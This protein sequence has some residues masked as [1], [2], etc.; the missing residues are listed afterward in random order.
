MNIQLSLDTCNNL[1]AAALSVEKDGRFELIERDTQNL[2]RGHAE[3]LTDQI[4][5]ILTR[6]NLTFDDVARI[7]VT[8]GP[9]SFTGQ[10]VGLATA[11]TLAAS[12]GIDAVGVGVLDALIHEANVIAPN[13]ATYCAISDAKRDGAYVKAVAADGTVL[14]QA[15][16][17]DI[18]DIP[19]QLT[20][21][22]TRIAFAG[23]GTA[24]LEDEFFDGGS[25]NLNLSFPSIQ[26][27]A[28]IGHGLTS[29]DSS[30][31][32]LYLRDADAKPQN[33]KHVLRVHTSLSSEASL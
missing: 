6:A 8:T 5:L 9:G 20:A 18:A 25:T 1:C 10:R 12:L 29:T 4:Q 11:R 27:I 3:V 21:L 22:E 24:L 33:A 15:C 32:P 23:T 16:L 2:G 7:A 28:Q 31:E 17:L 14:L 13:M 26:S 19:N 30:A